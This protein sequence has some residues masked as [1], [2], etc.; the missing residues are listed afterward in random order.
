MPE[1]V[2]LLLVARPEGPGRAGRAPTLLGTAG[3]FDCCPHLTDSQL[4]FR[5]RTLL[6]SLAPPHTPPP[7]NDSTK[8]GPADATPPGADITITSRVAPNA[9]APVESVELIWRANFGPEQR[10]PMTPGFGGLLRP[11]P[12]AGGAA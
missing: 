9:G 11:G 10:V 2:T 3:P 4:A 5:L 7:L 8:H 1:Q 12:M 6:R